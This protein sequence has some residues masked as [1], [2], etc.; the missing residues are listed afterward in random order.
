MNIQPLK[1]A[2][3]KVVAG[4]VEGANFS[5]QFGT[6]ASVDKHSAQL[7]NASELSKTH[8]LHQVHGAEVVQVHTNT[9]SFQQADASFTLEGNIALLVS[10]ADCVPILLADQQGT[11]V[12]VA[13]AGWQGLVLNVIGELV[14]AMVTAGAL[15][16]SRLS[17]WVCPCISAGVYEVGED[18]WGQFAQQ[19][20]QQVL[21]HDN[22]QKRYLNL[23]GVAVQQ[24]KA[25]GV[26]EVFNCDVC[27]YQSSQLYSHRRY[28]HHGGEQGRFVS[29]VGLRT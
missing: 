13:H 23:A 26:A 27:T 25:A 29:F 7:L 19:Y 10:T 21:D 18:V 15:L 4:F 9:P 6:Q 12:G 11:C 17:G 3:S 16:P 20:P 28:Q 22:L 5:T 24:L 8:K 1:F 14:S 2:N